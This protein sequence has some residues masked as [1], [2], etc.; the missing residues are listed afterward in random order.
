MTHNDLGG[1]GCHI[2]RAYSESD[3]SEQVSLERNKKRFRADTNPE[4]RPVVPTSRKRSLASVRQLRV[5]A[6]DGMT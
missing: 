5:D 3:A 1:C 2:D 6:E 4:G